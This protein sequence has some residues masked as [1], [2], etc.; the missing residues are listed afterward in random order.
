M[1]TAEQRALRARL[2][3]LAKSA[4]YDSKE[5]TQA[6][7]D[8]FM[9]RFEQEVDPDGVLPPGERARRAEAAKKLYFT[10]L[11][12]KSAKKRGGTAK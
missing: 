9:A 3:G 2:G 10:K 11:A 1:L 8:K 5:S 4:M 12:F 7:R 6:A